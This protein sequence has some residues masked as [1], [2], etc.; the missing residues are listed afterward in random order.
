M[1]RDFKQWMMNIKKTASKEEG[2]N[3]VETVVDERFWKSSEELTSLCEPI[4]SL[5]RLVDGIA[6]CVGKVYW[7]MFQIENGVEPSTVDN[8]KK[9]QLRTCINERWKMM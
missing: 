9:M 1:D 3:V 5:L 4:I 6:P 2:R 7:K 8:Q